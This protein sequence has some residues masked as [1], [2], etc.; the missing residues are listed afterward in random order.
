[1]G[2][3]KNFSQINYYLDFDVGKFTDPAG[4]LDRLNYSIHK[5]RQEV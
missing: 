1:M 2:G 4:T 5:Q 3:F